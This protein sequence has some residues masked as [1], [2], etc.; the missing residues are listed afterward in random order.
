[1]DSKMDSR[2]TYR[3]WRNKTYLHKKLL[4][5]MKLVQNCHRCKQHVR[6]MTIVLFS[7]NIYRHFRYLEEIQTHTSNMGIWSRLSV[8][9]GRPCNSCGPYWYGRLGFDTHVRWVYSWHAC[10]WKRN[11]WNNK[12]KNEIF[13]IEIF[14]R[15]VWRE[16]EMLKFEIK[17]IIVK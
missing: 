10:I 1:M 3:E 14:K 8:S 13:D 17:K 12:I 4:V 6:K 7:L 11:I 16:V 5:H 15:S 9:T 2:E